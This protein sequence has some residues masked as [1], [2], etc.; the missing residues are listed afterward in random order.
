MVTKLIRPVATMKNKLLFVSSCLMVF[1]ELPFIVISQQDTFIKSYYIVGLVTSVLN[2]GCNSRALQI[3]DRS[4]MGMG[5]FVSLYYMNNV[6]ELQ[7]LC[8]SVHCYF[9]SKWTKQTYFHV[10]SHILKTITI[11]KILTHD[12]YFY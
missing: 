2:H 11:N 7:L 3:I 1:G 8:L 9:I 4:V 12:L 10:I 5:F 6:L